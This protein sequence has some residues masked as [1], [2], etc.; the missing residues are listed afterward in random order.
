MWNCKQIMILLLTGLCSF[1]LF[2][3]APPIAWQHTYGGSDDDFAR[4]I[5]RT[6][7][8]GYIVAGFTYSNNGD[9]SGQHG[10][11]DLW[12]FKMDSLGTVQWQRTMG[13]FSW[14]E[15][16]ELKLTPDGG[17]I[18]VGTTADGMQFDR[19]LIKLDSLGNTEWD[20]ELG[21][22][23]SDIGQSVALTTDGG[24]ISIGGTDSNNGDVS[25][26]HG[27]NDVWVVKTDSVGNTQWQR[28]YGGSGYEGYGS[29]ERTMDD[30]Y[31]FLASSNSTDGD[32]TGNHGSN[33]LWLVKVDPEGTILWQRSL[34]GSGQEYPGRIAATTDGG[35]IISGS[36]PSSDGDLSANHGEGDAW[37]VKVDSTGAIEWQRSYGGEAADYA[38]GIVQLPD[39]GYLFTGSTMSEGGDGLGNHGLS[40]FWVMRLN[41][42]GDPL[43]H[44]CMGGSD[45]DGGYALQVLPNGHIMLAG[46]AQSGDGDVENFIG[47][48]DAWLIELGEEELTTS[49]R[50]NASAPFLLS[51]NP[52]KGILHLSPDVSGSTGR[53]HVCN[54]LGQCV[55]EAAPHAGLLEIDLR[56]LPA[57]I[58]YIT[59]SR[60][61]DVR[62]ARIVLN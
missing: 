10:D 30:R 16:E 7:E 33:D 2:G 37:I 3:Q 53:I 44:R 47:V 45:R 9:V 4:S 28:C 61:D 60:T 14:N 26:N 17:C 49:V 43:W 31:I 40:D 8:G 24:Y 52:T 46:Y 50:A 34:G 1:M 20:R 62:T 55:L 57:G 23:G 58:Y 6:A 41:A 25:G 35:F 51:P 12:V 48:R 22:T 42:T 11:R 59:E 32:V 54:E 15:A 18:V 19:W 56:P 13:N 5:Q 38:N 36:S 21:G 29:I 39:G 27:M